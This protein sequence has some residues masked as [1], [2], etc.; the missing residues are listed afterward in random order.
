MLRRKTL[1][2]NARLMILLGA[3]SMPVAVY[4]IV[5][6]AIFPF[7]IA[8]LTLAG[9][10][11]TL[12]LHQRRLFDFAAAGQVYA[13]L[14]VGG[15]LTLADSN[16]GDAGLAI[17]V[18]APVMAALLG[19]PGLRRH[20]W[21]MF[22]GILVV[23]GLSSLLSIP[24]LTI[25]G[26]ILMG[27]SVIAF[28]AAAVLIIHTANRINAAYEVYDKAQ[29]TAYR[30]LIEHVQDGVI[31][32]SSEGDILMASRSSEKLF[33]C[34]RF[35]LADGGLVGRL[36]VLDRPAYLNAFA[37]ANQS[38][39]ARTLEVR[40][41]QDDPRAQSNLPHFIWVEVSLSPVVDPDA[42]GQR[43][44]VVALFRDVTRRKDDEIAMAEAR[45]AAEEASDAKSRFL[46]TIGHELRTP[47]NA[48]V[49]FSE[50]MTSGIGGEL[51]DTHREYA[52]LIHQSGKHLLEVVRMLLDM[53]KLEA[54]KFELQTEPFDV[55]DMIVPCFSMVDTLAQKQ[56]VTL[57]ADVAPNLP[58]L[59]ADERACRQILINLMSNAI[60]FS[61]RGGQVTVSVKR[62][63]QS[64]NISVAD[65]GVG[66]P[67]ES[68]QRIGEPFFQAH[69]GLDRRYEGTGLGLSI[70][71]G[72]VDLH[73]GTLRAMS[74]IGSGTTVT[75]LLPINGPA[76]KTE[77][78]GSVTPFRKEPAAAQ[79]H[80]WQD[81][82][83]KAQ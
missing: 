44:E 61:H 28:I 70:V 33:G 30:H 40:L 38:G 18:M 37:D 31:R 54:G 47:L 77:E 6:G 56:E 17:A 49:G 59:V 7:V 20:S 14:A 64:L 57:V 11:I 35:E 27:T 34:R 66:M 81:E 43:R 13:L 42:D 39:R 79:I 36:H 63:G 41:R 55:E 25:H 15:L 62:Q 52:G 22:A 75:V 26:P 60:K 48:V 83:R 12:A 53:S 51:S 50:M 5:I 4:A 76:I 46:A 68:L 80:P 23:A 71:K 78:T 16:M 3:L 29:M 32:F 2:N 72:L 24:L 8:A 67:P 9:G 1:A 58:M 74:E 69:D 19:K 82:K 65:Q 73:K 21:A 45:R 10:M